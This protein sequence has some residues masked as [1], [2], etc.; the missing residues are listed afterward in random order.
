ML[1]VFQLATPLSYADDDKESAET[2][3]SVESNLIDFNRYLS[4]KLD[5][6][7]DK[8]DVYLSDKRFTDKKNKT[9]VK[10]NYFT[11]YEE[12]GNT[13]S[14]FNFNL[15]LR[16]PNME[17]KWALTFTSYD[18]V[19]ESR[20]VRS[21]QQ[22]TQP[23][24]R[25]Y[26]AGLALLQELG[27]IRTT[28]RPR[29]ELKDP[30]QTRYSLM[31]ESTADAKPY[32]LRPKLELFADSEQ[33]TGQFVSINMELSTDTRYSINLF[34][35]EQYQDAKNLFTTTHG[36]SVGTAVTKNSQMGPAVSFY[37]TN[38]ESFHLEDMTVSFGFS[39][40]PYRKIIHY[41]LNPYSRF[42]KLDNFKGHVGVT[43][44]LDLIF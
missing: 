13:D 16:L 29:L 2:P 19:E 40:Q 22:R 17:E 23:R 44:D 8:L 18:E 15:D 31:F 32:R 5:H 4:E 35:E 28:F 27:R 39:H 26:G 38:R 33:G 24:Q 12:G 3:D 1:F 14:S 6:W 7:A 41:S 20:G 36:F 10:I 11:R 9:A 43:L 37:S 25:N 42:S 30:L 21:T 34:S